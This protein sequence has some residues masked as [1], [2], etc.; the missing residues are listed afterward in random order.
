MSNFVMLW[1][2]LF[3]VVSDFLLS[4]PAVWFVGVFLLFMIVAL[5]RKVFNLSR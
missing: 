4:E 1:S 2:D 3:Q 5:L